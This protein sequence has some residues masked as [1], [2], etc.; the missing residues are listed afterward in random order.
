L[1]CQCSCHVLVH[2]LILGFLSCLSLCPVLL[3]LCSCPVLVNVNVIVLI[4]CPF[5]SFVELCHFKVL[6]INISMFLFCSCSVLLRSLSCRSVCLGPRYV[7]VLV[8]LL[9]CPSWIL[10]CVTV[11]ANNFLRDSF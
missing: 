6:V 10:C 9:F 1:I 7:N 4:F 3:C 2:P 11:Y 5:S 8:L